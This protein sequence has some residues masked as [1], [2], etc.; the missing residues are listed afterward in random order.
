LIF[1]DK[2]KKVTAGNYFT[3]EYYEKG[4]WVKAIVKD[5]KNHVVPDERNYTYFE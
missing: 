1:R 4:N 3:Y 5:N 2:D